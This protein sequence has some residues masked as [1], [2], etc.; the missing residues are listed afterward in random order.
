MSVA[1]GK[2]A[3]GD[4]FLLDILAGMFFTCSIA[5]HEGVRS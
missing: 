1:F 3:S 2:N 4:D 5:F